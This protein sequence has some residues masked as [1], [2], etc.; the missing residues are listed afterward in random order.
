MVNSRPNHSPLAM[1]K[2]PRAVERHDGRLI[3][4]A[5]DV[6]GVQIGGVRAG[7]SGHAPYGTCGD[8]W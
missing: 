1:G 3:V 2:S 4:G 8:Q 7:Q 6:G 5:D